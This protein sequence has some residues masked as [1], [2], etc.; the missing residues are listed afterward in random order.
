MLI[1][2]T[3]NSN[4]R[5]PVIILSHSLGG[6]FALQLLNRN[7]ISWR[8]KLIK[9]FIA[10]SAPWG[11]TVEAMSTFASGNSFG[12]P[13]VNPLFV[14]EEQ[15]SC[16]SNLWLMPSP[17]VFK[18]IKPLVIIPNDSYSSLDI[19]RLLQ[20]IGFVEGVYPYKRRTNIA[21]DIIIEE[22]SS[23]NSGISRSVIQLY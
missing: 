19:A 23:I 18:G 8:Q 22:I 14:R 9:H 15:R 7:P 20:D 2:S 21:L 12:V 13:L 11:G 6:L 5:K 1:E 16:P 10:L 4:K 3:S 17:K